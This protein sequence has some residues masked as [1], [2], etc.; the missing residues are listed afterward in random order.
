MSALYGFSV[1]QN[2]NK[3]SNE[4]ESRIGWIVFK[5][6]RVIIVIYFHYY[7]SEYGKCSYSKAEHSIQAAYTHKNLTEFEKLVVT[8]VRVNMI[9]K[10]KFGTCVTSDGEVHIKYMILL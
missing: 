1:H 6:V 7:K 3:F 5:V 10:L 2:I 4:L 8:I 9:R